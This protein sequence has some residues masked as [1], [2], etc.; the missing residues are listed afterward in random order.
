MRKATIVT[1]DGKR[2]R[3]KQTAT[4]VTIKGRTHRLWIE[5]GRRNVL[6]YM[7]WV[8]LNGRFRFAYIEDDVEFGR[9]R[10]R[11]GLDVGDAVWGC[12]AAHGLPVCVEG[13]KSKGA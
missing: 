10:W 1:S 9:S 11:Y 7:G 2:R 6:P 5:D 8:R 12:G 13:E 3:L 4:S